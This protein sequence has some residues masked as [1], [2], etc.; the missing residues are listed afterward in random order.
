M[1]VANKNYD[2]A[3]KKIK[4]S[5]QKAGSILEDWIAIGE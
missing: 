3:I 5:N 4:T 2:K 1:K